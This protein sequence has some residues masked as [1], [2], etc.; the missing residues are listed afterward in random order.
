MTTESSSIVTMNHPQSSNGK[1][2]SA[3]PGV[4]TAHENGHFYSPIV[5]P[6]TLNAAQ[7]WPAHPDI[8]GVNFNDDSHEAILR[9]VFPRFM[10]EYD[11]PERLE[12]TPDL[13]QFFTQNSQFSWL[14]SRA[15]FVL[16][17]EWRPRRLIEV[18]SGF[19]TLLAADV[20]HRFLGDSIDITC[21]EP[22][23]REFLR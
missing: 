2:G 18:G 15:L 13:K 19:S 20:N 16:L 4:K 12:E 5:D 17:R 7:L 22:Y 1:P 8:I 10:A 9:D 3:D 14:D 11:Y 21:V 23:P 6:R